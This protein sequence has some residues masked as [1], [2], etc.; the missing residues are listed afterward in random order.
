[1]NTC[2]TCK[3]YSHWRGHS[4]SKPVKVC[5]LLKITAFRW[6]SSALTG[7]LTPPPDFVCPLWTAREEIA[8]CSE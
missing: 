8:P 1:M 7:Y 6:A 5:E 3:H 4:D 2:A